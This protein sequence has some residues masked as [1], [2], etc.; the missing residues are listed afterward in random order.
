MILFNCFTSKINRLSLHY[1]SQLELSKAFIHLFFF[2]RLHELFDR[3]TSKNQR[4]EG[5]FSK[6]VISVLKIGMILVFIIIYP[7]T[8]SL[9]FF[10]STL[11]E[12][13][14]CRFKLMTSLQR[15]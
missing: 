5:N 9:T 7:L 11:R 13:G 1:S 2:F 6:I 3:K 10:F 14:P 12:N 8:I 4:N 15:P